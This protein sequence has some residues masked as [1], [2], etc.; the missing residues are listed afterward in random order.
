MN[1]NNVVKL[2]GFTGAFSLGTCLQTYGGVASHQAGREQ[3]ILETNGCRGLIRTE[4]A[5]LGATRRDAQLDALNGAVQ[6]ALDLCPQLFC[7]LEPVAEIERGCTE[8]AGLVSC[9]T[10]FYGFCVE[11]VGPPPEVVPVPEAS[12]VNV[13][14]PT[15]GT[16]PVPE[17]SFLGDLFSGIVSGI[18]DVLSGIGDILIPVGLTIVGIAVVAGIIYLYVVGS[19]VLV[20]ATVAAG[21]VIIVVGEE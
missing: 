12:P 5:G 21:V 2:P 20:P 1:D 18:G 13:P 10:I 4:G 8:L 7:N 9:S 11:R 14:V 19:P 16:T 17:S 6:R 15:N 3:I